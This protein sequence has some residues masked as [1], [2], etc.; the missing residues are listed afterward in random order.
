[1]LY[2]L[3]IIIIC[4]ILGYIIG[5][6]RV[7]HLERLDNDKI[8]AQREQLLQDIDNKKSNIELLDEKYNSFLRLTE[9]TKK[10][11][12]ESFQT[13]EKLHREKMKTLDMEY[14]HQKQILDKQFQQQTE[15]YEIEAQNLRNS[16]QEQIDEVILELDKLKSTRTS[17]IEAARKE[18]DVEANPQIYQIQLANDELQDIN[19]L[20]SIKDKLNHPEIMGK[21]I[22]SVFFQKKFKSFAANILGQDDV[23]GVYKITDQISK[24]AYI[25]RAVNVAKR[26]SEHIK[27]GCGASVAANANQLYAAMRRDGIENFSF[28][29][30]ESCLPQELDEKER[31]FI[32]LYAA[33]II[34]LNSKKGNQ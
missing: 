3:F 32:D 30:L 18:K 34:G 31:F 1:M 26:W 14:H 12:Q 22:W 13:E 25:G 4:F 24:E 23:C 11:A 19:Y 8:L 21:Y 5:Q 27:C 7:Q 28:E 17:A 6:K 9:Q 10:N 2:L 29:L 33:D 15:Q 16:L 20:N